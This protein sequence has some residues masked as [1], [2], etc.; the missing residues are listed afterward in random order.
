MATIRDVAKRAEVSVGTVSRVLAGTKAVKTHLRER[1]QAAIEELDY[2]PNQS[3]RALRTNRVDVIGLVIPDITNPFFA[4]LAKAIETEAASH[5]Q[6]VMLA[7]THDDPETET[8]QITALLDRT[9][10][11]LIVVASSDSTDATIGSEVP[12]LSI[13]RRFQDRPLVCVDNWEGSVQIAEHL[14]SLGHRRICYISGPPNTEVGRVRRDGFVH[15]IRDLTTRNDPV[16]LEVHDSRFNF[17]SGEKIGHDILSR[18]SETRPTAVAAASDQIAIG[19]MR[20]ARDR[21][22]SVPM[23]LAVAGFDDIDVSALAFPRLTT[24]RQPVNALA[25]A[26][27]APIMDVSIEAQDVKLKGSLIVRGSTVTSR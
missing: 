5:G 25:K 11:G 15:R 13:D 20:A 1:V 22:L 9:P 3:A 16:E 10:R 6:F 14:H 27:I 18:P 21:G 12:I 17:E 24:I 7:N 8:R 26:V 2:K 4:Q 23:D 19:V